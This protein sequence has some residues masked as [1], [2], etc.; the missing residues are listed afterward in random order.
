MHYNIVWYVCMHVTLVKIDDRWKGRWWL[1]LEA[2]AVFCFTRANLHLYTAILLQYIPLISRWL[3]WLSLFLSRSLI[4]SPSVP[5]VSLLQYLYIYIY[6]Y[7]DAA[8][9]TNGSRPLLFCLATL[10][11]NTQSFVPP[12]RPLHSLYTYTYYVIIY[13][14]TYVYNAGYIV[15]II[16]RT[17]L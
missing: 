15:S 12:F 14:Y 4:L 11:R 9:S 1:G 6:A 17:N 5:R 10:C 13:I 8:G 7:S 2:K 3:D 16:N